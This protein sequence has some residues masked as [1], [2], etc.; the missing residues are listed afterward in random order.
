M[1]ELHSRLAEDSVVVGRFPLSLLLLSKDAN[2]PWCILVPQREDVF[3]IHHLGE[4]DQRQLMT[5]SCCLAEMMAS[6][7][8]AHKM[9]VAA[10]GNRVKQLHLHHIARFEHDPAWPKPVWDVVPVVDYT[11]EQLEDRLAHIRSALVGEEFESL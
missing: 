9:N 4:E 3:E 1:F 10:L 2:Y 8:D 7:F 6:V 11:P 5:E